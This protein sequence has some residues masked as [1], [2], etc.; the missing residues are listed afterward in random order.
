LIALASAPVDWERYRDTS[1]E[2]LAALVEAK[3]VQQA[4]PSVAEEPV[5]LQLLDALKQSVAAVQHGTSPANGTPAKPRK[6]RGK[7]ASG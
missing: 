6:P 1:A 7:R 3:R 5:V 2:E 4:P